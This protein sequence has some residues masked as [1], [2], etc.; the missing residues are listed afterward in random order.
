MTAQDEIDQAIVADATATAIRYQQLAARRAEAAR[1]NYLAE[2]YDSAA[3]YQMASCV[4]AWMAAH[5]RAL[6]FGEDYR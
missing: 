1:I 2:C 6:A 3:Y 5:W 4:Y